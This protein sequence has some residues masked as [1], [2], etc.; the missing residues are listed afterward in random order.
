MSG[1]R[2]QEVRYLYWSDVNFAAATVRV[3]HQPGPGLDT[4]SV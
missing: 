1:M 4:K 2:E 3:T